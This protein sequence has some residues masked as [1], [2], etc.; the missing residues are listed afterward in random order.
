MERN[1]QQKRITQA[2]K[3]ILKSKDKKYIEVAQWLGLSESSVKRLFSK[4]TLTLPQMEALCQKLKLD[5]VDLV[6]TAN[7]TRPL[8]TALTLEQEQELVAD[9]DLFRIFYLLFRKWS[10]RQIATAYNMDDV[11]ITRSLLT[12]EELGLLELLPENRV[13]LLVSSQLKWLPD[14]PIA[15]LFR[16][17][18]TQDFLAE[19]LETHPDHLLI[20]IPCEL[21][22]EGARRIKKTLLTFAADVQDVSEL[23]AK[24]QKRQSKGHGVLLAMRPW[25][26]PL[27]NPR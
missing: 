18:V 27:F 17:D 19:C 22:E 21:S 4:G 7:A 2:L 8:P 3:I 14:G 1:V 23:E 13:K 11:T 10:A 9:I 20:F 5:F 12:L 25:V 26:H 16:N 6:Q 24:V 15:T